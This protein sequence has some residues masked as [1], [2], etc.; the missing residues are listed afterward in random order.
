MS[1]I[2]IHHIIDD[3]E[4]D[5]LAAENEGVEKEPKTEQQVVRE[6]LRR[7]VQLRTQPIEDDGV[8]DEA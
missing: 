8:E 2:V 7:I 1:R 4:K 6:K 5:D 3:W